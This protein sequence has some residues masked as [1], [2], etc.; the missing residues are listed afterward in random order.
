M[1]CEDKKPIIRITENV[2]AEDLMISKFLLI[3]SS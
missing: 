1:I 2:K 3:K